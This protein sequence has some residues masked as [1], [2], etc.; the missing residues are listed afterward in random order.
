MTNNIQTTCGSYLIYEGQMLIVH[1]TNFPW[2]Q[3]GIPKGLPD[4]Y[5]KHE[6][7]MYREVYEE[8][9]IP[10]SEYKHFIFDI[11]IEYYKHKRKCLHGFVVILQEYDYPDI[12]CASTFISNSDVIQPEIDAFVWMPFSD[13]IK[14]IQYEQ[15][16][17]FNRNFDKIERYI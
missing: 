8:T 6:D 3:W 9:N 12:Y 14:R 5:E 7:A 16:Q 17:L 2:P 1:S 11:G 15:K 10:L 13:A 4:K